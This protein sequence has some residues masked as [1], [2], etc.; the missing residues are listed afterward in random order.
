[1]KKTNHYICT[2]YD[3]INNYDKIASSYCDVTTNLKAIK[4]FKSNECIKKF[5][6]NE[7]YEIE[8]KQNLILL[9]DSSEYLKNWKKQK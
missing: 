5:I 9:Q 3:S 2:V 8:I 6:G 7:R 4:H 1:M